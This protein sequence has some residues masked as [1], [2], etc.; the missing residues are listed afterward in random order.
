[1][2]KVESLEWHG[3][4]S[5]GQLVTTF[6]TGGRVQTAEQN[7]PLVPDLQVVDGRKILAAWNNGIVRYSSA[8]VPGS[9]F[10]TAGVVSISGVVLKGVVQ[11]ASGQIYALVNASV[12]T[13]LL[14]YTT[15]GVLDST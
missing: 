1:M 5:F 7:M 13:V 11:N 4:L 9:T 12:G 10:G 3:L 8:G 2:F 14:R 15:A 6:A